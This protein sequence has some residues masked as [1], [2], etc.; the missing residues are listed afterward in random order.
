[1]D[2][3][4]VVIGII[5][6]LVGII[7][8]VLPVL[9]GQILAWASLLMLQFKSDP[10]FTAKFIVLWALIT[11]GVTIL[12]YIVPLWGTKKLGGSKYGIWGAALGLLVGVFFSPIGLI[13]GP[14]AGAFVGEMIAGKDSNTAFKSGL[15]SFI[16]FL[17]GTLLKLVISFVMGYYF[18]MN[19]FN[20]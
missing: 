14:F 8:C 5:L 7:G 10:P 19:A 4:F 12:D 15:G 16:G 11:A 13:I 6:L 17:T 1:M 2:I 9:P 20:W 3:L 18:F